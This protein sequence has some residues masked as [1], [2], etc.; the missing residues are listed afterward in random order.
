MKSLLSAI[1]LTLLTTT[2]FAQS[3]TIANRGCA[4]PPPTT[5]EL[6]SIYDWASMGAAAKTTAGTGASPSTVHIVG[7][8]T[9]SGY[10]SLATLWKVLCNTNERFQSAGIYF[11]LKW[12]IR[13]INNS[14]YYQHNFQGG[15]QMMTQ[16]NVAN[17]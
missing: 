6:Q 15:F 17:T 5:E 3:G 2:A 13:Y 14:N 16:H 8:S 12:P 10:Y 4:T 11:H 9:G 7:T 1:L